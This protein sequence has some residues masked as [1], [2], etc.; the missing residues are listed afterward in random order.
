[1]IS[2]Q[3][4]SHNL[5]TY[6]YNSP[7]VNSDTTG[8]IAHNVVGA[9]VGVFLSL[10]TYFLGVLMGFDTFNWWSLLWTVVGGA[11]SGALGAS[12]YK[13]A[14]Q[15]IFNIID[16]VAINVISC[17]K[18]AKVTLE[19]VVQEVFIGAVV[20]LISGFVGGNGNGKL[21]KKASNQY[22]KKWLSRNRSLIVNGT[23]YYIKS[24]A[25]LLKQK[26]IKPVFKAFMAG[27]ITNTIL[28]KKFERLLA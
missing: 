24:F 18:K 14:I 2:K 23:K 22:V 8:Y 20:G 6:C 5:F 3:L 4:L 12:V 27:M 1:M 28:R 11:A 19:Q 15:I 21:F 10:G 17:L 25:K 26:V 16:S 9:V 7:I 13:R